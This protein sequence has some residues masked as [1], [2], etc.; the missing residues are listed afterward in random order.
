MDKKLVLKISGSPF[1]INVESDFAL[2]LE[3]QIKKD[4]NIEGNNDIKQLLQAYVRKNHK[5]YIQEK[6]TKRIINSI[7]L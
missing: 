2:Y 1:D 6:E 4:F 7:V 5:L 3:K